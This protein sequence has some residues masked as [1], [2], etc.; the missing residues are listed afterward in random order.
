M[1][2][3]HIG[4]ESEPGDD[5][6]RD[7]GDN[8]VVTKLLACVRVRDMHL[9]HGAPACRDESNGVPERV[10][11]VRERGRVQDDRKLLVDR[12]VQ[13]TDELT[14]VV[15]L[16]Q[17]DV[18]KLLAL[19]QRLKSSE[20]LV[21]VDVRLAA[22]Q[23]TKVGSVQN[24]NRC[25]AA[26]LVNGDRD[27][28]QNGGMLKSPIRMKGAMPDNNPLVPA[29]P[30]IVFLGVIGIFVLGALVIV[31]VSIA[32]VMIIVRRA[33]SGQPLSLQPAS[34]LHPPFVAD[35]INQ[36]QLMQQ[37]MLMQQQIVQ[38]QIQNTIIDAH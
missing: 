31:G 33:N 35:S 17:V 27:H 10:G 21:A 37:Q 5:T 29:F 6:R 16:A 34:Q 25:H 1:K 3:E 20:V 19:E 7:T 28:A 13:P 8:A 12:L 36:N 15:G 30:D 32:I 23:P 9:D 2:R 14:L 11:V 22:A 4:I 24:E 26:S 18:A 38:Q